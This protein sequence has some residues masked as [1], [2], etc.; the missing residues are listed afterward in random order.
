MIKEINEKLKKGEIT[1]KDLIEESLNKIKANKE[2][3]A[4][5][6]IKENHTEPK[7]ET[8]LSGIPTSIKDNISTK[9][10]LTTASSKL[11]KDY[12]PAFDATVITKLKDAGAVIIGKNTMDELGM[13]GTGLN[14]A[15][16]IVKNPHNLN[17]KIGGSSSGS[18]AAVAAGI[19]PYSIASDTGDSICKPASLSGIVGYK[20]TYGM[21]SRYG[22]ISF[23]S[24]LDTI[25]VFANS[26][27]D[28]SIVVDHI[29]GKDDFDMTTFES[30]NINLHKSLKEDLKGNKLFYIKEIC[31]I[32]NYE[33]PS[34]ELIESLNNFKNKINLYKENG[35]EI[36]EISIDKNLIKAIYPAYM[37]ISSSEAVS[38]TANLTGILFGNRND[39]ETIEETIKDFR[40]NLSS[41]VKTRLIT[42]AYS[43]SKDN[44]E[45]LYLNA[46]KVRN[47][48]V[49]E[50][51]SLFNKY[52]AMMLPASLEPATDLEYK[53]EGYLKTEQH[54]AIANFG[55][56][57]SITIPSGIVSNMAV[58]INLTSNIMEDEK[59]LNIAY[60]LEKLKDVKS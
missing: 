1:S 53:A 5:V 36:T 19:V 33:N 17:K 28:A 12:I 6:T 29:K 57:P 16:G 44:Y 45:E 40:N 58:G 15:T 59:L 51:K 46:T 47:I 39:K 32:E 50:I 26:V 48:I 14:A 18:A 23:A 25:G 13:G 30:S 37:I 41:Q 38:N 54:L 34:D 31:D 35:F 43:L 10:M 60:N 42:G 7:I 55:G 4:F 56:F 52:D 3:N 11:L 20:P 22:L 2:L 27:E 24:S 49:K 21:I 8:L 9:D